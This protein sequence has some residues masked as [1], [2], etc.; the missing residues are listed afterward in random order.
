[1]T[2]DRVLMVVLDGLGDRPVPELD[3]RTPLAVAET[4]TLD[5]LAE[6]GATATVDILQPGL[7]PGSDTGHL[8]LLGFDPFEVYTGRGPFEAH[9]VGVE[10]GPDDVAL[11]ANFATL[12]DDGTVAD[13]RAGRID[14]GTGELAATID[15]DT[16]EGTTVRLYPSTAHRAALVLEG[17][18]L[19]HRIGDV[20]PH[21]TGEPPR[22]CEP[23]VDSKAARQTA[24][25]VDAVVEA[26]RERFPEIGTPANVLLPR[27]AG[28]L[29]HDLSL[30]ARWGV[31]GACV[32]GVGLVKGVARAAGMTM[33]DV[34]GATGG[35]DTDMVAKARAAVEALDAHDLVL[36]NVKAPDLCGHDGLHD[37]K[38]EVL[39]RADAALA[40]AGAADLD[41][42]IV[43]VTGD[44]A[45]PTVA[46][47]HT[48]DPLPAVVHGEGVLVDDVAAF[49]ERACRDGGL[50]RLRGPDLV[51]VAL[52]LC[53][54]VDKFGA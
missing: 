49:T 23:L 11:R 17:P 25:V 10:I 50:G 54:R 1:M 46:R 47:D 31:D 35:L 45:T 20:D 48:G 2:A 5:G 30:E 26:S 32:A 53:K 21:A 15:G 29:E 33:I 14:E 27:G 19:S 24:R 42:T 12:A 7:P 43:V 40:E 3:D 16:F 8:A 34:P 44:H 36:L 28:V 13:R 37:E 18:G 41:D 51:R 6:A 52:D 4:P 39:E 22:A 9:G 38:V